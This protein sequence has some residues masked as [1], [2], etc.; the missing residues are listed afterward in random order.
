MDPAAPPHLDFMYGAT[1]TLYAYD[2]LGTHIKHGALNEYLPYSDGLYY[3][4]ELK[5]RRST[6]EPWH[7]YI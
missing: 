6:Y 2:M 7:T 3:R 1:Y 4:F 5:C